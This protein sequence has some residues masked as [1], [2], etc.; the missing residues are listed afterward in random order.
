MVHHKKPTQ[1]LGHNAGSL[2]YPG[3]IRRRG[4]PSTMVLGLRHCL[5]CGPANWS[6]VPRGSVL[7]EATLRCPS[8]RREDYPGA[9]I[10]I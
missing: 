5:A 7:I 3:A 9:V 8:Q 4:R 2:P 10:K 6:L 1:R